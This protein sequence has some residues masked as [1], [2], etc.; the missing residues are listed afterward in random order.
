[1]KTTVLILLGL[2]ITGSVFPQHMHMGKMKMEQ[3][4][5]FYTK[6]GNREIYHLYITDTI[7]NYT[8][9]KRA[10]MAINGTIP[11]PALEFT[12]GDTAEIYV[13][14][15]MMM[16]TSIHWHGVILPN[17][18]DGVSYLTTAPLKPG[19]THFY[20]F[21]LV[22]HG[23]LWYHSHTMT[24]QQSGLYG[25]F[26]IHHK[27]QAL[28]K[29]YTLLLSD[30]NDENPEQVERS[31]H[32]QTDWYAIKKG[33]TQ[34][35]AEAISKGY[36]SAKLTN[37]WKRM[38]AMDV[39]DVYY[40]R[41]FSNGK[42]E[43]TAP[44]FK[45]GDKVKLHVINGSSSTYFWL[46]YAG[47]K[48]TV[49]ATDGQEVE[50]VKV[51]RMIIAVA[52]TYDVEVTIPKA[53]SFEFLA[54]AE[55]R[56][57]STSLWLGDGPKVKAKA[58]SKLNYFE[59]MKMMNGMMTMG[60]DMQKMDGM[61]MSNQK[62][63]M[64]SVMYP[65]LTADTTSAMK[66]MPED[67]AGKKMDSMAA[68]YM[69]GMNMEGMDMGTAGKI[70]TL[71]YGMLKAPKPTNL[72]PGPTKV[73]TFN[74]TGNM[75]RYVW[76]INN[77]TVSESDKILIKKGENV[78]I[79]LYNNTMMRH[80]MHLHGH[81]FRVLNGQGDY[82]PLKNTL[83]I[84]PMETDTIEFAATASGDWFFHCHILYHMMSGMGRIFSYENSPPNP[85]IPDS[86]EA[87]K[88][89]YADDRHFY[90][91][92]KIGLESNGS[93]GN[94]SL[95]NT[96]WKI[97]TLWKIGTTDEKGYESETIA[98]RYLRQM[99]WLY[100]YAGFN[101]EYRKVNGLEKNLFG[102]VSDQNNRH[103]VVAGLAYTLPLLFVADARVDGNG[104][105]RLQLGRDDIPLTSRLRFSLMGNTDKEYNAGLRYII[106]KYFSVSS[107]Y[108]SDM[109]LGAGLTI[110]Y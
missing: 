100:A 38:V 87:I 98:G 14:N 27:Q 101:Y 31:L 21:P 105:F 61:Q 110:V 102:Q 75:N 17:R 22:Q 15:D 33:S 49:I 42:T 10:A 79:L 64:N 54:T 30:W 62:M 104:K 70:I 76:T 55:D 108:D 63:D 72:P 1:M 39:S 69:G 11:A 77:K 71:N 59:G 86:A 26:I 84:M 89:V 3:H 47:G 46:N 6:I 73:F 51:D 9:K 74:L 99:Q 103:T 41:F 65:E 80:P 92:A 43:Q 18:Y 85:E 29:E 50:P 2:L 82:A 12:E 37:E 44:Q 28:Q 93:D 97:Q 48:I 66:M 53:G 23:T 96:R 20:K 16:E 13:H 90:T 68:T 4:L 109:G 35:Y 19:E 25:A 58:L 78:R 88:K 107:H 40:N 67:T 95:V 52:E 8:G 5:P 32:N 36:L 91:G 94:I 7:V 24:Q 60:G 81:Y 57:N 45:A 106:T 34:N 56:S 83:D